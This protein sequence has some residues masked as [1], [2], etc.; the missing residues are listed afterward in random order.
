MLL[1]GDRVQLDGAVFPPPPQSLLVLC[2]FSSN[3][4]SSDKFT[5][6]AFVLELHEGRG[7]FFLSFFVVIQND[8]ANGSRCSAN[9]SRFLENV[10]SKNG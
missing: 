4:I 1:F 5:G 8:L 10:Q 6:E 3:D 2:S 7:G 9:A